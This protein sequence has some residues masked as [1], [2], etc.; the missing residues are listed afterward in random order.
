MMMAGAF[1]PAV[2]RYLNKGQMPEGD[3]LTESNF[4]TRSRIVR[5][6]VIAHQGAIHAP[7][8]RPWHYHYLLD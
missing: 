5:Q 8:G 1:P 6:I 2:C 4:Q 3:L 7:G